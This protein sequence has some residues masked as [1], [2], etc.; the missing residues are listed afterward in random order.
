MNLNRQFMLV[1]AFYIALVYTVMFVANSS[2]AQIDPDTIVGAWLFDEGKG[3]VAEDLSG[4][5]HNGKLEKGPKW[6]KGQSGQALEFDGGNYVELEDSAPDLHFGDVEPFTISV[7]VNP[8]PGGTIIGKFNGGVIGAYI[9]EV[10]GGSSVMFHREVAPWGLS[11]NKIVPPKDKFSH[12]TAT[13]DGLE[14]KVYVNGELSGQQP[15]LGQ[16]KD[17]ATP[18]LVGARFQAS[19]PSNFYTGIIDDLAL[20]NVALG[21]AE[22]QRLIA[23]G[24]ASVLGL[25]VEPEDRLATAWATLKLGRQ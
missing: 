15:R 17:V 11:A 22:I 12:I 7:W 21:E 2:Y 13:Y 3:K 6:V 14:M 18:V 16:N 5:Q 20:F 9:L 4:G 10:L 1:I 8:Q 24:L 23:P 25:I 19:K